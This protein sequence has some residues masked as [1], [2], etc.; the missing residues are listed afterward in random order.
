MNLAPLPVAKAPSGVDTYNRHQNCLPSVFDKGHTQHNSGPSSPPALNDAMGCLPENRYGVDRM[1][2]DNA[3]RET[4]KVCEW[5][6][7]YI[8][9]NLRS[10]L[11]LELKRAG[12][13][14]PRSHFFG[15][16]V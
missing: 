11:P 2:M 9:C 8:T 5:G 14:T 4:L 12:L 13:K 1:I 15:W 6:D 3:L 10:T 16:D 7:S